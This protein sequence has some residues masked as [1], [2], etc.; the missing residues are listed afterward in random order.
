VVE[1]FHHAAHDLQ[2]RGGGGVEANISTMFHSGGG[3]GRGEGGEAKPSTMLH[4][5]CTGGEE[6]VAAC[7][8]A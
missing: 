2:G 3:M 4:T 1:A 6:K 8:R 7:A 5:T